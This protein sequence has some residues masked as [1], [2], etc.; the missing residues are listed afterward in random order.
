MN[1]R[2]QRNLAAAL[3]VAGSVGFT[4]YGSTV[5]HAQPAAADCAASAM[6]DG[7]MMDGQPMMGDKMMDP[8]AMMDGNM[9]EGSA[10]GDKVMDSSAMM[11]MDSMMLR[12]R[13]GQCL[14]TQSPAVQAAFVAAWGESAGARW[15]QDH[16][17]E[18]ARMGM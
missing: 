15:V 9:M 8:Q 6:M 3:L 18:L 17:A 13:D 2:Q 10:M 12:A 1:P 14:A 5:A 4:G 7:K 11:M 16:E